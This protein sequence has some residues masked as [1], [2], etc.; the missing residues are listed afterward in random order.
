MSVM[1]LNLSSDALGSSDVTLTPNSLTPE[2]GAAFTLTCGVSNPDR[3]DKIKWFRDGVEIPNETSKDLTRT[4]NSGRLC[5]VLMSQANLHDRLLPFV[6]SSSSS[7]LSPSLPFSRL[8]LPPRP[9]PFS[10]P[11][12]LSVPPPF[13]PS[14]PLIFIILSILLLFFILLLLHVIKIR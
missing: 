2:E 11:L 10:R 4:E 7:P 13:H 3:R 5:Y 6:S 9:S 1:L 8:P 12:L 14:L